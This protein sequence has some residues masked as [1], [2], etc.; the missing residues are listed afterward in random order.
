MIY[1]IPYR[2]LL[3]LHL[4]V[5]VFLFPSRLRSLVTKKKTKVTYI[6]AHTGV[7][8]YYYSLLKQTDD[9]QILWKLR[10]LHHRC[11]TNVQYLASV[12]LTKV[13]QQLSLGTPTWLIAS[14]SVISYPHPSHPSPPLPH[15]FWA[16]N[17]LMRSICS[18][19]ADTLLCQEYSL[20]HCIVCHLE[21]QEEKHRGS[22]AEKLH[23]FSKWRVDHQN[24]IIEYN[25][26]L[27]STR[28]EAQFVKEFTYSMDVWLLSRL[29]DEMYQ[30]YIH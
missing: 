13:A 24:K 17:L 12:T 18:H 19:G 10:I 30:A 21:K 7:F 3:L 16:R 11:W 27:W 22:N 5:V 9:L 2:W 26:N 6:N 25:I 28:P 29:N 15:F 8:R 23:S 1:C 4:A 14:T 20:Q